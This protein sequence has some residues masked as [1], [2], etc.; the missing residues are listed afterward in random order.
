MTILNISASPSAEPQLAH[1]AG[2]D[3][4]QLVRRHDGQAAAL[5]V[6]GNDAG[7]PVDRVLINGFGFGGQNASALFGK[8]RS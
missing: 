7:Q 2:R 6:A 8:L 1:V 3:I 5:Q 4:D